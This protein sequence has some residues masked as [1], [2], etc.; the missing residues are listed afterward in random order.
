[1]IAGADLLL[2]SFFFRR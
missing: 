2:Q 1:M